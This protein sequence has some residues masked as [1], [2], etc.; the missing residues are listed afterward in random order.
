[1]RRRDF[2][3]AAGAFARSAPTEEF[4][5][6][7]EAHE[8]VLARAARAVTPALIARAPRA[9]VQKRLAGDMIAS[10]PWLAP[11]LR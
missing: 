7:Q 2:L 10:V 5:R 9:T 3:G 6:L 11:I 4:D 1:M 8:A